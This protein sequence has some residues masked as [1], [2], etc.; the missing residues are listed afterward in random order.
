MVLLAVLIWK[1]VEWQDLETVNFTERVPKRNA[2]ALMV[3]I[4]VLNNNYK[5]LMN[6]KI[7]ERFQK[8]VFSVQ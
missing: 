5:I 2:L 4:E 8:F 3:Q 6:W 1:A 7:H